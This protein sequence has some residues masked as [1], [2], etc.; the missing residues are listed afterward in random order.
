VIV[1]IWRPISERGWGTEV[2][3]PDVVEGA[4]WLSQLEAA[5]ADITLLPSLGRSSLN[6]AVA[7]IV[8]REAGPTLLHCHF[9]AF[10]ISAALVARRRAD[11]LVFWHHHSALSSDPWIAARN[12]AKFAAIGRLVERIYCPAPDLCESLRR[13][14]APGDR[15]ALMPNAIDVGSFPLPSAAERA[16]ARERLGLSAGAAVLLNFA[17]DWKLKGGELFHGTLAELRDSGR[18]VFG[19]QVGAT[20]ESVESRG[21]LGLEDNLRLLDQV[22]DVAELYSAADVFV[23]SSPAEGVPFAVIEALSSG[24]ALAATDIP[25][26]ALLADQLGAARLAPGEPGAMA[27]AIGALLDRD[28]QAVEAAAAAAHQSVRERYS[29]GDWAA[30]LMAEYER[31]LDLHGLVRS[32]S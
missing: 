4:G 28:P 17:W 18:E 31:A 2:V 11:A 25:G 8:S 27:A 23:A 24:V 16:A 30:R 20:N 19:L 14:G 5:G 22:E 3:L 7:Q 12:V 15:V 26:H 6:R 10:D 13:R 32:R 29:L 9:T 1:T 21:R